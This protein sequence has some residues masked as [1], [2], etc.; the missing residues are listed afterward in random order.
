MNAIG[1]AAEIRSDQMYERRSD[2]NS[3]LLLVISKPDES[4][5][6][7]TFGSTASCQ[8]FPSLTL[9]LFDLCHSRFP[10]AITASATR[11]R[12]QRHNGINTA[13]QTLLDLVAG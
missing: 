12:C 1:C 2:M 7:L 10:I 4:H 11:P 9:P 5:T 8:H 6:V 13:T 3:S